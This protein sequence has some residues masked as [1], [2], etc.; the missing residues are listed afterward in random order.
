MNNNLKNGIKPDAVY[1]I[2][3]GRLL[4]YSDADIAEFLKKMNM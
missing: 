2:E 4:G 3:M 1:H